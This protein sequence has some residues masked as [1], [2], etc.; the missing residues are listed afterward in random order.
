MPDA[1]CQMPD[2]GCQMPDAGLADE[3]D[4]DIDEAVE[5]ELAEVVKTTHDRE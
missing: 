1:G 5:L 3:H 2:A 4:L